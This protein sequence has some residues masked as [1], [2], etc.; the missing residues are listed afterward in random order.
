MWSGL[1]QDTYNVDA[2][3][4]LAEAR[5]ALHPRSRGLIDGRDEMKIPE[6]DAKG[7]FGL[8][9]GPLRMVVVDYING[10]HDKLKLK[11]SP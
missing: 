5:T 10:A 9:F 1:L 3:K 4:L 11:I 6:E 8:Y 2:H 7:R